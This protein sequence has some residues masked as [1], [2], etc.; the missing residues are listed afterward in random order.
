[1]ICVS[2]TPT[3]R[4]LAKV[5]LLNASR[6]GDVVELCLDH[7][8][9]EPDFKDILGCINKPI[10]I[11]CRRKVDG[12]QWE[13]SEA[14]RLALLRQAIVAGPAYIELDLDIAPEVPRFGSTKRV[15][16]CIRRDRP[17]YDIDTYF[18]QAAN[19]QADIVKFAWPT[20]NLDDAWPLLAAVSQKRLLPVVGQ[21][22]GREELTFSLLGRKYN[23]PWTY[24]ALEKGMEAH[25]GQA[26]VHELEETYHWKDINKNTRLIGVSG[27][28]AAATATLTIL[29]NA[30]KQHGLNMRCLPMEIGSIERLGKMLDVLKVPALILNHKWSSKIIPLAEHVDKKDFQS[31]Y[32]DLLLKQPDGW[33]GFNALWRT[34]AKALKN[35]AA[36]LS[37]T[38]NPFEKKNV[39]V[40]G[41]SGAASAAIYGIQSFGAHVNI[42]SPKDKEAGQ[43]AQ[44]FQARH[45][46]FAKLHDTFADVVIIA[47][48]NLK[49]GQK[50]GEVNPSLFRDHMIVMDISSL[51]IEHPLATEAR[52]RGCKMVETKSVYVDRMQT[53]F[54]SLTGKQLPQEIIEA[55]LQTL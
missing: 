34:A 20:P 36:E 40:L 42:S 13:G 31:Q 10:L 23:S 17:E 12:G 22:F 46:Q 47:D 19:A 44:Q 3:S 14:A 9:K 21:G 43:L 45:I 1:M 32:L 18:D 7:L 29:N 16:S 53:I 2:V 27:F 6:H 55:G 49:C 30:F 5:D 28:D 39:I 41:S 35:K 52:F 15:I 4:T 38:E 25:E 54:K 11:S 51:P 33:H 24:A 8:A 50:S 37:S 48:A 26:S